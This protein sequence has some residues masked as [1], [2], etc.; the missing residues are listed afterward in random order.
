VQVLNPPFIPYAS[1]DDDPDGA[2]FY[3]ALTKMPYPRPTK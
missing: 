2:F 1:T 3:E